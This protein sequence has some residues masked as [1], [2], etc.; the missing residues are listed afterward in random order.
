MSEM[1]L[2]VHGLCVKLAMSRSQVYR[3][4]ARSDFPQ[5]IWLSVRRPRWRVSDI[6]AWIAKEASKG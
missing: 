1:L 5:P 6:D 2:T 3:L 4:R